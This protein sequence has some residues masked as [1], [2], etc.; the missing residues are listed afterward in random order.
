MTTVKE[1]NHDS[2]TVL[3]D[4]YSSITD[5][6]GAV[7]VTVASALLSSTNGV[8]IDFD[9]GAG[10]PL[11]RE[12]FTALSGNDL[13]WR[14]VINLANCSNSSS[15]SQMVSFELRTPTTPVTPDRIAVVRLEGDGGSG[16][17]L[18]AFAGDDTIH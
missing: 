1:I 17:W 9:A 13:R 2:S 4:F 7:S 5:P 16:F 3:S 10:S 14:F 6:N 18:Q 11:L 15:V 12:T 8:E